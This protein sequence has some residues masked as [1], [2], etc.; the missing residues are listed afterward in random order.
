MTFLFFIFLK[1]RYMEKG[2]DALCIFCYTIYSFYIIGILI[3][4]PRIRASSILIIQFTK[5]IATTISKEQSNNL[6]PYI[7]PIHGIKVQYPSDW[8]LVE[9]GDNG[10]HMLNVIAEF[11]LPYQSNYYNANISASHNSLRLSVEN[12][13]AFKE[14]QGIITQ[15]IIIIIIVI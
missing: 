12:Y 1:K 11:L 15:I 5:C 8:K 9:R 2:R 13:S 4:Y 7:N 6:I 3:A 14:A 10:Y